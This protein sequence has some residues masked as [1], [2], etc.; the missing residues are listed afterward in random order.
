MKLPREVSA[1]P[2]PEGGCIGNIITYEQTGIMEKQGR[3][4]EWETRGGMTQFVK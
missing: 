2:K 4:V 1:I 3:A